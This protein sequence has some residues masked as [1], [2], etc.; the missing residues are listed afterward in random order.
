MG[1]LMEDIKEQILTNM[2]WWMKCNVN[3]TKLAL[4]YV[5][6]IEKIEEQK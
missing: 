3:D 2:H 6:K 4:S 5:G 1:N